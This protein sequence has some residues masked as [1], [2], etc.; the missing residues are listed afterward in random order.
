MIAYSWGHVHSRLPMELYEIVIDLVPD[1]GYTVHTM[2]TLAMCALVCRSW[3]PL[4]QQH[5]DSN[6]GCKNAILSY[7][8]D[9]MPK[10]FLIRYVASL[11][12]SITI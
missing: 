6:F 9:A 11:H 10:P 7:N 4:A 3:N 8:N 2:R 1:E 12:V 5:L